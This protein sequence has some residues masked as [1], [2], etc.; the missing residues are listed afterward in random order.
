MNIQPNVNGGQINKDES[1]YMWLRNLHPGNGK[2]LQLQRMKLWL[3]IRVEKQAV[4]EMLLNKP[5]KPDKSNFIPDCLMLTE[6]AL[7][8]HDR[9]KAQ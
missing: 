6:S 8:F 7:F 9:I 4:L 1:P 2:P 3:Q 5:K